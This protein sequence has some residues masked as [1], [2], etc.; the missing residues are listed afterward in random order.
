[1]ERTVIVASLNRSRPPF[2]GPDLFFESSTNSFGAGFTLGRFTKQNL[3]G[4][5][6]SE[7]SSTE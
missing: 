6:A 2:G 3:Y 4:L 5:V 1:M 7:H